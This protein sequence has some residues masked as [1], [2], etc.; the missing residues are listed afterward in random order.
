MTERRELS[1]D[2][3]RRR[4]RRSVYTGGAAAFAGVMGWRWVQTQPTTDRIPGILRDG[5]ELNESIWSTLFRGDHQA[6]TFSRDAASIGQALLS[7]VER[8]AGSHAQSDDI[9]LVCFRRM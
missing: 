4:S 1:A 8:F 7:D 6:R 3:Y 2:D 5:H 9:C